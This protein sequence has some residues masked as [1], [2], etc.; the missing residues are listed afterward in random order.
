M[1]INPNED[2][3]FNDALR[4]HGIIPP[5]EPTPPSPSPPPSPTLEEMLEDYTPSELKELSEDA[6]DDETER[7]IAAHRR[8]R[9]ALERNAEK[10][11]RF[12]RVYPI[13]RDDYTREVTDASKINEEEDDDEKGTGV[14]C[15]LYKDGIPRSER[16]FEHIRALAA[17]YPRTKF[18][19]IVGD[20]CIPNL[21]D[22][23]I[24][25]LIIY[26]KGE[27]RN[28]VIA[29]GSDRERRSEE[30]EAILIMTGAVDVPDVPPEQRRDDD[31]SDDDDSEDRRDPSARMRSAATS[32]NGRTQKNIR[33]SGD[34]EDD[35]DFEFDL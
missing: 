1:S 21:P 28:Q 8:Q 29:W 20:K 32:T 6:P 18:V 5:R 23:R 16:T 14:I 26:R 27:I 31:D 34:N 19:S 11:A 3:E 35:S 22:S 9:I 15:F 25:M 12:G 7:L 17:R 10:K 2:T 24:P 30:L 13:G 33:R 4:K